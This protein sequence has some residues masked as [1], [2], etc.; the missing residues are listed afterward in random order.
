VGAGKRRR[1]VRY[2]KRSKRGL[3]IQSIWACFYTLIAEEYA[4]RGESEGEGGVG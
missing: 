2:K 1:G 4:I 3:K